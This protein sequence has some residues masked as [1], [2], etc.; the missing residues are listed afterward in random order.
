ML[1]KC[2]HYVHPMVES[3]LSHVNQ[4]TKGWKHNKIFLK[5]LTKKYQV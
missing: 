3:E 4:T 2:Y 1:L 5:K